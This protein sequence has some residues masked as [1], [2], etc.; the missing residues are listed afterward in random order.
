MNRVHHTVTKHMAMAK[1]GCMR[2]TIA[3]TPRVSRRARCM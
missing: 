2:V 3:D 1:G